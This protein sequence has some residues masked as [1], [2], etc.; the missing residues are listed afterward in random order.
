MIY[1]YFV[2]GIRNITR[3]R[4]RSW[5]TMIGI[6]IGIAAVVALVSLG[7]GLQKY[8]NDEFAKI[9]RDKI[10]IQPKGGF[11]PG[12]SKVILS[13]KDINTIKGVPGVADAA[14][15]TIKPIQME[16][17][18]EL[19]FFVVAGMPTDNSRKLI[20][21]LM[22][23]KIE[24]G[25][26]IK[27]GDKYKVV[28]GHY[29]LDQNIFDKNLKVGNK[30]KINEVEFQVIGFYEIIGNPSDDTNVYM[31][32]E[33]LKELYNLR[34]TEYSVLYVKIS[35][36]EEPLVM[37]DRIERALRRE[38]N[39]KE[40]NED[41]EIQTAEELM[42]AFN[43]LLNIVQG[44]LVG[45]ALIS[46]LVGAIGIM[47]TMYT[48]VLERTKEIGI[49]KAVGAQ[50]RD[51]LLI[52]LIES[53]ILGLVGGAIGVLLG[54]GFSSLVQLVATAA[55]QSKLLQAYF[56]WYLIVGA[57]AFSFIVGTLSGL[58]PA[59]QASKQKPVDSLRYE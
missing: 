43:T 51:I 12:T 32:L 20:D 14:G 31:P 29:F 46:L 39:L 21:E 33:T 55:L 45:I 4:L 9:G 58:L 7:Q 36:G 44:V 23:Y 16:F 38:R 28:L 13:D 15:M 54:M 41:F 22:S 53:G 3:R 1:D 35:P 25:R 2:I 47:N 5:L 17:N 30:V 37:V 42:A 52:F 19:K 6:F 11:G 49:L 18:N 27:P 10:I 8:I 34:G 56:P 48:A 24:H 50:N 59:Y 26:N 40:G 57:L